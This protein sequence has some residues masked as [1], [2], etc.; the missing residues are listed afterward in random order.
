MRNIVAASLLLVLATLLW[1]PVVA[2]GGESAEITALKK[3]VHALQRTVE[4]LQHTIQTMQKS[5]SISEDRLQQRVEEAIRKQ[6]TELLQSHH[7][8]PLDQALKE[9]GV[10]E[11][12]APISRETSTRQTGL[13]AQRLI[14]LSFIP[15]LLMGSSTA[16]DKT[17]QTL[18]GGGHDPHKRGFTLAEG[19]LGLVGA[20]DPYFRAQAYI[21]TFIDALSGETGV[22]LEEAFLTTQ[23]LPYGLQLE[24]GHFLTEF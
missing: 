12:L 1:G 11:N 19:E 22:E 20:V 14:D 9:A 3:Q 13:G 6:Q 24:V 16:R 4:E 17:L 23:S 21:T 7:E 10:E 5:P 2:Y 18:Q 15:T 8:S